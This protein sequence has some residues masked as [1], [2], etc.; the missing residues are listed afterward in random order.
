MYKLSHIFESDILDKM[1]S[2]SEKENMSGSG[3]V[4]ESVLIKS[5]RNVNVYID[6]EIKSIGTYAANMYAKESLS[7][8]IYKDISGNG[9]I[10]TK[11]VL[12]I[13]REMMKR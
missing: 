10:F 2:N 8:V 5:Y 4:V 6:E 9:D 3:I 13:C 1:Y 11:E 7:E 12:I